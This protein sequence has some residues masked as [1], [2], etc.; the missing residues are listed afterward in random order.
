MQEFKLNCTGEES[1]LRIDRYLADHLDGQ[2]RNSI[3]KLIEEGLVL[4]NGNACRASYKLQEKDQIFVSVPDAVLTEL[5]PERIPLDILYEDDQLLIVNKPKEM[6]VHPAPG[7][8][9]GTLVNAIMYHC[10]KELSG[11]NGEIRPGIVHR[12]DMNTTGSLIVCKTDAAHRFIASQ[13][14]EHSV[15]RVYRAIVYGHLNP[16]EG[17]IRTSIGRDPRDRKKMSVGVKNGRQ[18]I[19]HYRELARLRNNFSY[20][21]F[22]LETGRTHQIR[23]HM[24]SIG[25][26]ILGDQVYGPKKSPYHLDGQTLHA[27]TIGFVH[28]T[29]KRY[30]E[31]TAPLPEYF[32]H[33]LAI[34]G[35]E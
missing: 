5:R 10:G 19:T 12:I 4:V 28:P 1:G 21:E 27:M 2:S 13:I 33:L 14:K 11:I 15:H 20:V 16:T 9:T 29:S 7:H 8:N 17:T 35:E 32:Q 22:E 24:A 26:P 23:V 18:A 3:Q 6:V 30:V 31:F 25:H 34:L